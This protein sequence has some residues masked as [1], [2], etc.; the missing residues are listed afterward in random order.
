MPKATMPRN[1]PISKPRNVSRGDC[2]PGMTCRDCSCR[3]AL[4]TGIL[5]DNSRLLFLQVLLGFD[6]ADS[7]RFA[8]YGEDEWKMT[9]R[10]GQNA[11]FAGKDAEGH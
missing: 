7:S 1:A 11:L 10:M 3:H 6:F 2:P 8:V 4:G 5:D 9:C